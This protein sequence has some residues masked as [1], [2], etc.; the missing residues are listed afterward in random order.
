[1]LELKAILRATVFEGKTVEMNSME[2]FRNG[3]E[4]NRCRIP[5]NRRGME[6]N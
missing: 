2:N 6:W 3:M 5:P 1:M 4:W